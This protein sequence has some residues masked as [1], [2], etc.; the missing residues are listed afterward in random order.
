MNSES[1]V[2]LLVEDDPAHAEIVLRNFEDLHLANRVIVVE[3]GQDA[4]D[5]LFR[6]E[7][8]ADTTAYPM[9]G[10]VLLDL[11]LP[12]VD[13]LEVLR[14]I[15]SDEIVGRIPVVILTT[16]IDEFDKLR[17]SQFDA[18]SYLVKPINFSQIIQLMESLGFYWL[19]E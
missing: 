11:R 15:K 17:A 13:G 9:P 5:Y 2:I 6:R 1:L 3:N 16:S 10:L 7:K 19:M 18:N 4:L 14:I 12:K 8:F